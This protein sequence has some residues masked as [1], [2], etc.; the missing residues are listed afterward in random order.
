MI[1][2]ILTSIRYVRDGQIAQQ[3]WLQRDR[4]HK[5]TLPLYPVD[6]QPPL[7]DI[8]RSNR[9]VDPIQPMNGGWRAYG[10]PQH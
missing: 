9:S 7:V 6:G 3:A 2:L 5:N 4:E 10:A 8:A 1:T